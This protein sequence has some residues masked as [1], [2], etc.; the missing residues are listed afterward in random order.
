MMANDASRFVVLNPYDGV[1]FFLFAGIR[2][3]L[4]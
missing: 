2:G 4:S 1:G 3:H